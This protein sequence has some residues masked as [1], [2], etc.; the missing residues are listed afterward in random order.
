MAKPG[1]ILGD[2]ELLREVGRGSMGVVF[3]A[4]QRAL[5]RR[6]A[7]KVLTPSAG[8]DPVWVDRFRSEANA[9]GRLSHPGIV[10][11]Y[12]VGDDAAGVPWFAME[13]VEGRDL[14]DVLKDGGPMDPREAARIV[15][16]AALAL[17]HAHAQGVVH[18]DVKPGNLMLRADGRVAVT[19]FGHTVRLANYEA[20]TESILAG[21]KAVPKCWE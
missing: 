12:A 7:V 19:D 10:S 8:T 21:F 20:A 3:E 9:V 1:D 4:K 6:V 16:D 17:S 18:R 11:I 15:R 2:F 14:S 13:F 5:G